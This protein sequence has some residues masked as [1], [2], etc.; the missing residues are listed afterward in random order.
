MDQDWVMRNEWNIASTLNNWWIKNMSNWKPLVRRH[1]WGP[2]RH[3]FQGSTFYPAVIYNCKKQVILRYFRN[4]FH[5]LMS[6]EC[7][8]I[9]EFLFQSEIKFD[10]IHYII[11]AMAN[12]KHLWEGNQS[13]ISGVEFISPC[14]LFTHCH[15]TVWVTV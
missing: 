2:Y 6:L 8:N 12:Q 3:K 4:F 14:F 9:K 11:F 13:L 1:K 5:L 7:R 10:Q 15:H